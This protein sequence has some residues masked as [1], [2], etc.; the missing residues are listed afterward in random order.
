MKKVLLGAALVMLSVSCSK[1][2]EDKANALIKDDM[3]KVLYHPET[4]DPVETQVDSAF[5]PFDDPVFYEKTVQLC[6]LQISIDKY[7]RNMKDAKS[8]MSIWSSPYESAYGRNEYQEAKEEYD[9]NSQN[10]K[11][12]EIKANKLIDELKTRLNK[13]RQ[14][15]GFKAKHRYRVENNAGQTAFGEVKY[16]FDESM[17]RVIVSYDME[18]EEYRIVQIVYNQMLGEDV[19]IDDSDL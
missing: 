10:K 8:S 6:K 13:E 1:S 3:N 17:E 11:S 16:L 12:A 19:V 9:E 4:Y 2:L 18:S 7:D 5:T 14:F 15:I